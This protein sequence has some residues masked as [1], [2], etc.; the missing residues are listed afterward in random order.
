MS[1]TAVG[2][3]YKA[4]VPVSLSVLIVDDFYNRITDPAVLAT[5]EV[6]ATIV[7]DDPAPCAFSRTSPRSSQRP[8]KT[9]HF[10]CGTCK[11]RES[12]SLR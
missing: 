2:A 1:G 10:V 7:P 8:R 12:S 5:I 11:A 4:D 9:R 3:R 6:E